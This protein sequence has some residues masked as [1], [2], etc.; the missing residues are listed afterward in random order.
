MFVFVVEASRWLMWF[1]FA[2]ACLAFACPSP[3][4]LLLSPSLVTRLRY[5]SP[6]CFRSSMASSLK[7]NER[8]V[9]FF[10]RTCRQKQ[11]MA[12]QQHTRQHTQE[13]QKFSGVVK[14]PET[15]RA[16]KRIK[17]PNQ[18]KKKQA[19]K[20]AGLSWRS[21][22]YDYRKR[23]LWGRPPHHHPPGTILD[24]R[25]PHSNKSASAETKGGK[26]MIASR[27]FL[28]LS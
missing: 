26:R 18:A 22:L 11:Y 27:P 21:V 6:V 28:D 7:R 23:L 8:G 14:K 15:R 25:Y 9:F 24:A 10:G 16:A 4:G 3:S 5:L 13:T 19:T 2:V 1:R 20:N 12:S 17:H